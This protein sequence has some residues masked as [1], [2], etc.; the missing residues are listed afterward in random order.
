MDK[1]EFFQVLRDCEADVNCFYD[2]L[3]K[4]YSLSVCFSGFY[5]EQRYDDLH[6]DNGQLK[7]WADLG[8]VHKFLRDNGWRR[9]FSLSEGVL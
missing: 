9:G 8:R 4:V 6:L 5:G 3:D 7:V 2:T 1:K